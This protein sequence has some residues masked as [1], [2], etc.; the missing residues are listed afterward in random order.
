MSRY[1]PKKISS[2]SCVV[3]RGGTDTV[4]ALRAPGHSGW[5]AAVLRRLS[6]TPD[7]AKDYMTRTRPDGVILVTL[8]ADCG[9]AADVDVGLMAMGE[10]VPEYRMPTC[11]TFLPFDYDVAT[12][13]YYLD[14]ETF[15]KGFIGQVVQRLDDN[16]L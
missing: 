9:L 12:G 1:T 8:C 4:F 5:I 11:E 6:L 10:D 3:C 14:Y 7:E 16:G 13:R 15:Q 2:Q